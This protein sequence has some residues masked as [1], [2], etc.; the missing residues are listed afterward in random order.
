MAKSAGKALKLLS[1]IGIEDPRVDSSILSPGTTHPQACRPT[2]VGL[3]F[4]HRSDSFG[5]CIAPLSA[6]LGGAW[7]A[8]PGSIDRVMVRLVSLVLFFACGAAAMVVVAADAPVHGVR[9]IASWPHDT[10][11]F[12]QG[13]VVVD[14]ALYESTGGYG[15]STLRRV[16]LET[17]RVLQRRELPPRL[18]AEGLTAWQD[19]LVQLTWRA[20][21]GLRYDRRSLEPL[22]EFT[23]AGEG[24]GLTHDGTDWIVSDGSATLRF[25]DP[26]TGAERRRVRVLD[27][28]R[29]VR[30]LNELE[31]VPVHAGE[32]GETHDRLE[33]WANVWYSDRLVRIDPGDG[34]VLGYVDLA[35][36]WPQGQRPHR[37][38]VLN[39]IAY[40]AEQRRLL[41]TGKLWPRLYWIAV[42]GLVP[43][44][45]DASE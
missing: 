23:L 20:G 18:F 30:R 6:W 29:P 35:E 26:E 37:E 13:L 7:Y 41:V 25:L 8:R 40:D 17:G 38:A 5:A 4:V 43:G 2:P 11:A 19:E 39:G 28:R 44:P 34:R 12:T 24:W 3:L 45:D 33:L 36:L 32:P 9:V 15:S 42:P 31:M 10:G 14:G 16:D 27:G 1:D 22:G 21:V